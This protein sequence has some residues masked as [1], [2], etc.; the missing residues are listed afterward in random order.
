MVFLRFLKPGLGLKRWVLLIL[1]G[2]FLLV[3]GAV[4]SVL[5]VRTQAEESL[6]NY[7]VLGVFLCVIGVALTLI[8]TY[9]L[10]RRVEKIIKRRDDER[11]ITDLAWQDM[12][13]S[14]G[15]AIVCF[16]GGTGLS[17]L[18][19][20]LRDYSRDITAIV[21]VADDGGSSGRIRQE[22]DD[23]LPVRHQTWI[24]VP[25]AW[26]KKGTVMRKAMEYSE[27]L[28]RQLVEGVK[29]FKDGNSVLLYPEK[30]SANF[31]VISDCVSFDTSESLAKTYAALI[32]QWKEEM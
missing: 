5:G 23:M 18:L 29:I 11:N 24:T 16:G 4:I 20:G 12:N 30:E 28:E 3:I 13:L 27:G 22:L 17:N 1:C 9:R 6:F 7:A 8:G 25:V 32:N 21:S 31:T 15:P 19:Y 2:T 10:M 26:E 14:K